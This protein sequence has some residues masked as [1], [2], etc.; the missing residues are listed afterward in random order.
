MTTTAV[1]FAVP[2]ADVVA[3]SVPSCLANSFY[4]I[5]GEQA[6]FKL[7]DSVCVGQLVDQS[8]PSVVVSLP[9]GDEQFVW[10]QES[11]LDAA[12]R[13]TAYDAEVED[14]FQWLRTDDAIVPPARDYQTVLLAPKPSPVLS[15]R[16]RNPSLRSALVAVP[17]EA[18]AHA[19][20]TFLPRYWKASSIPPTPVA[21]LPVPEDAVEHVRKLLASL[22]FDPVVASIV[23]GISVDGMRKN[24]RYLTNED[25]TSGIESRHSFSEGSRVAAA[26]LKQQFEAAG[27]T[28][29]LKPFLV[30]FAPNIICKYVGTVDSQ[31][32]VLISG[33]YDSRGSFGSSRAPGGNDDGSGTISL[34]AIARRIKELGVKFHT[35]VE[36]VAFA[37]EEQGLFGSKAYARELRARD[38]NVTLMIQADML[39]YHAPN[40]PPQLGLPMYIGTPEVAELVTKLAAIYSPELTVGYTAACCSDHQVCA[41]RFPWRK[42]SMVIRYSL[43]SFHQ[44][45]YAATQVFERA[46]PSKSFSLSYENRC[47]LSERPGYDL[48][49]VRYISRVQFATLLHAAG[50]EL[51][52]V[53]D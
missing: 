24:I 7:S 18:A 15:L 37:G 8:S 1:L 43:K 20:S 5:H 50:F 4:G 40:E 26:W 23:N 28:C 25:G 48:N 14:F 30:G 2:Y 12:L 10:L 46:G 49:Q 27:A 39:A 17:D 36:L 22:H 45:G 13:T 52:E 11:A 44:Q 32:I 47:D 35:N 9:V 51:P 42:S 3:Q 29:E 16:Y 31:S 6:V 33:H 21:Y 38:A 41:V 34:L 19:L 53:D